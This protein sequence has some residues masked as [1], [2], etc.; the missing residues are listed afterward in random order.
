MACLCGTAVTGASAITASVIR[1]VH[2]N[3]DGRFRCDLRS[4]RTRGNCNVHRLLV[5]YYRPGPRPYTR[6]RQFHSVS[7][8]LCL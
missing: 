3:K 7:E 2:K 4:E 1:V 6:R 5:H 8:I